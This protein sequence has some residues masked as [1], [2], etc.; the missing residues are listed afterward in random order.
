MPVISEAEDLP[1]GQLLLKEEGAH[2]GDDDGREIIAQRG[3]RDGGVLVSLEEEDPVDAHSH[4]GGQQ[5]G[6]FLF[7]F[8]EGDLLAGDKEKGR[9]QQRRQH[10]T[11]QR[12]LAGGDGDIAH[13]QA[14]RAENGH[15]G[16][17]RQPGIHL[18]LHKVSSRSVKRMTGIT[19]MMIPCPAGPVNRREERR[20]RFFLL[21]H[22]ACVL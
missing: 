19:K 16:D 20:R 22:K 12:Q 15:G 4:A 14:Q 9:Q 2:H 6:D 11:V 5:Q 10:G 21:I 3:G 18:F 13:K 1:A 8:G 17:Q 7:D